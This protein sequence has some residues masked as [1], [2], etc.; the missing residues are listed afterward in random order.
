[1]ST[2]CIWKTFLWSSTASKSLGLGKNKMWNWKLK[3]LI[4]NFEKYSIVFKIKLW[5]IDSLWSIF[6]NESFLLIS[7]FHIQYILIFEVSFIFSSMFYFFK[8][9]FSPLMFSSTRGLSASSVGGGAEVLLV[10]SQQLQPRVYRRT[11]VAG[12]PHTPP[13]PPADVDPQLWA[14]AVTPQKQAS[15]VDLPHGSASLGTDCRWCWGNTMGGKQRERCYLK[16]TFA[17]VNFYGCWET[18][19]STVRPSDRRTKEI[20]IN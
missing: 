19:R 4:S 14:I 11:S 8:S 9:H 1:M 7:P 5:L 2:D 10:L 16:A 18:G 3:V 12:P 13:P 15:V 6:L 20:F 17:T